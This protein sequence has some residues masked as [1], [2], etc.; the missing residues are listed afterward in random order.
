[1][2]CISGSFYNKRLRRR[3][4][5]INCCSLPLVLLSLLLS[6][7]N[8]AQ[9][10]AQVVPKDG[11]TLNYRL[12]G[13]EIP[14]L[15]KSNSYTLEVAQGRFSADADFEKNIVM[16]MSG[17]QPAF[18]AKVPGFG[19]SYTWRIS[20]ANAGQ[21]K[22]HYF[23]T[24]M[25]PAVDTTAMRLRIMQKAT[26]F[27]ESVV[28]LDG[29]RVM[30]DMNGDPIWY[31]PDVDGALTES[32]TLRDL[33][34]TNRGTITFL[35]GEPTGEKAYEIDYAGNVLWKGPDD[36]R[37]SGDSIEF[38]HHEFTRQS[39]GSY[40]VLGSEYRMPPKTQME[41]K[42]PT[43]ERQNM[44]AMQKQ[45]FG[46]VIEYD[47]LGKVKWVWKSYDYFRQAGIQT[48]RNTNTPA[49]IDVHQNAFY[50]DDKTN[51]IYVSF[52]NINRILKVH[53]PDGKVVADYGN[54][55]E[56]NRRLFC[57]QHAC[58]KSSGGYIYL[59]NNNVCE[60][61]G[62]P[63]IVAM[64]EPTTNNGKLSQLWKY[65]LPIDE[66]DPANNSNFFF[67]SG[68]NVI[69]VGSGVFFIS[70][71]CSYSRLLLIDGDKKIKWSAMPEKWNPDK[72]TW[73]VAPQYRASFT[74]DSAVISK[75]IWNVGKHK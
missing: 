55:D 25:L 59:F 18:I 63:S 20:A 33:K 6:L 19:K 42:L 69:E 46:T 13:F 1:M 62:K 31:L 41:N 67:P 2:C 37:I 29:N 47:S 17:G 32:A 49:G 58:K 30:Y 4:T 8:S 26:A 60:M 28:L 11:S 57:G 24:G 51:M 75:M 39:S 48:P 45:P 68:G 43:G 50:K 22:F 71:S 73:A 64:K 15:S 12:V 10:L 53:Y 7:V 65:E 61:G 21:G 34:I 72:Q 5:F 3:I 44:P 27:E 52:K 74:S 36:G 56:N 38:Y 70:M 35:I 14:K 9:V 66:I 54:T 40:M 16:K 23:S